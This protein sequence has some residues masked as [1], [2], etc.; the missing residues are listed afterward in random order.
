MVALGWL[1]VWGGSRVTGITWHAGSPSCRWPTG[2]EELFRM[3]RHWSEEDSPAIPGQDLR[4]Q[5]LP[6]GFAIHSRRPLLHRLGSWCSVGPPQTDQ[7][8]IAVTHQ[9]EHNNHQKEENFLE[10]CRLII[11]FTLTSPSRPRGNPRLTQ[12]ATNADQAF[13]QTLQ[14]MAQSHRPFSL[15]TLHGI[16]W[17]TPLG[18]RAC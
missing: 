15:S 1:V 5:F 6:A 4:D 14:R 13:A 2:Q 18:P 11:W 3:L 9:Q 17:G 7:T 10:A 8:H 12:R 16:I